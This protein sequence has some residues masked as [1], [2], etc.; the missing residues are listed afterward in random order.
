MTTILVM[1]SFISHYS[2]T[3][4]TGAAFAVVPVSL[5]ASLVASFVNIY[6]IIIHGDVHEFNLGFRFHCRYFG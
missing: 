3:A 2:L 6:S 5:A 4:D 1:P